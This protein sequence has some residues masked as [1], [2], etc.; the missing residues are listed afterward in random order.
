MSNEITKILVPVDG[1]PHA[2]KAA[3]LASDLA[4]RHDAE[5]IL[6]HALLSNEMPAGLKRALEIEL[7]EH[8]PGYDNLVTIPVQIMARVGDRR[9]NA[10]TVRELGLVG[11]YVLSSVADKCRG[12]GVRKVE[13]RVEEGRAAQV[14]ADVAKAVDAD[15]IVMGSRGLSD[16]KR[17]VFG[18]VSHEV[19]KADPCTLVIVQ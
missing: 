7:G 8:V 15:M 11:Q 10:L 16:V 19:A 18:S 12:K 6:L 3:E 13:T 1:S 14:I 2:L 17:L 5:I 4:V 9:P